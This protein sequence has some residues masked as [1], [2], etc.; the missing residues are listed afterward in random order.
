MIKTFKDLIANKDI[1]GKILFTLVILFIYRLGSAIPAPGVN[2]LAIS[3]G[4]V[5]NSIFSM[6][7]MLGG[8]SL[9]KM[10]IFA[11]GI[12]PYITASIII[13]LLSMDVIPALTEMTKNGQ[14]GR[15]Q[16]DRITRYTTVVLAFVQSFS[17]I[18]VFDNGQAGSILETSG[19]GNY[20]YTAT[21]FTAGTMFLLWLADRISQKGIGNGV[22]MLIFAGIV[23]NLPFQFIQVFN[24]LV[25]FSNNT[26]AFNGMIMFGVYIL[27]YLAIIVLVVF[28]QKAVRKIP[29]QYTSSA[30]KRRDKDI[31]FL[32]LKVNSASVIPVIFAGALMTVPQIALTFFPGNGFFAGMGKVLNMSNISGVLIYG[33]LIVLFTFF[34]TNL[35]VD[36]GKIAE[37]LNKSGTYIPGIRPG[38]ETKEYLYKVINRI[39]V[40]GALFLVVIA[41]IPYVLPMVTSLPQAAALGGTGIIIVVGVAMETTAQLLAQLSKKRYKGFTGR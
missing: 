41:M 5:D 2:L 35:Q 26:A 8:G 31:T 11:L 3:S 33:V 1:R 23:A 14:Q 15:M 18:Y 32:P 13:N 4:I 34:Y 24:I 20:I 38:S 30:Q 37:N 21:I 6:M 22:S 29:I 27:M 25:D 36:A 12:S 16:I 40:L 10:S 39:T 17:I 7:N 9:Q 19:L 28:M